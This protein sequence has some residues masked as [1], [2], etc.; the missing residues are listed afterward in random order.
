MLS[1]HNSEARHI[2]TVTEHKS[3]NSIE[4]YCSRASFQQKENM[5]N[6]L[7]GFISGDSAEPRGCFNTASKELTGASTLSVAPQEQQSTVKVQMPQ[8]FSFH[9]CSVSIETTSTC[10]ELKIDKL[11]KTGPIQINRQ[12][13][14]V[15]LNFSCSSQKYSGSFHY[16][17]DV[18]HEHFWLDFHQ[19]HIWMDELIFTSYAFRSSEFMQIWPN[20]A[21]RFLSFYSQIII[22]FNFIYLHLL[23]NFIIAFS[24]RQVRLY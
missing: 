22:F 14:L 13:D 18:F 21:W 5:S 7:S 1:D 9:G 11:S 6:I 12:L 10:D 17:R 8:S 19:R 23:T 16:L 24:V 2:K 4:S 3:D 20:R 15:H